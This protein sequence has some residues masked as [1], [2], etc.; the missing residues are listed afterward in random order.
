M[1]IRNQLYAFY[2]KAMPQ[3]AAFGKIVPKGNFAFVW[4]FD[5]NQQ[6][7]FVNLAVYAH[8]PLIFV[9]NLRCGNNGIFQSV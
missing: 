2:P 8:Y 3:A 7:I 4:I 9:I 6:I 5:V 1:H